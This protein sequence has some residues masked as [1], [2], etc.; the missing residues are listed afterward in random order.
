MAV[1]RRL[2]DQVYEDRK[3]ELRLKGWSNAD[4]ERQMS[5]KKGSNALT[6]PFT[7]RY[8]PMSNLNNYDYGHR[9]NLLQGLE[10]LPPLD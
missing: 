7:G 10:I 4:I 8:W 5:T 2:A 9:S 6:L 3:R 1:E